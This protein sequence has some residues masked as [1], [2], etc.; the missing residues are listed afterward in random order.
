MTAGMDAPN[1][2]SVRRWIAKAQAWGVANVPPVG[3]WQHVRL[4]AAIGEA[5]L[6]ERGVWVSEATEFDDI[7]LEPVGSGCVDLAGCLWL[8]TA[9]I[10]SMQDELGLRAWT[11]LRFGEPI[12]QS[13]KGWTDQQVIDHTGE[14]GPLRHGWTLVVHG[15]CT[16]VWEGGKVECDGT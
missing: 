5:L 8:R 7:W 6:S 11:P 10:P 14:I 1:V 12:P 16:K 9:V 13:V 2:V 3:L 4:T 15:P